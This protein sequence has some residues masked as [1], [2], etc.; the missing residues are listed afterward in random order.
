VAKYCGKGRSNAPIARYLKG[1]QQVRKI[2]RFVMANNV[3]LNPLRH[4][5]D[6]RKATL[7][8]PTH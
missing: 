4:H 2:R 6:R 3:W 1:K 7:K 8:P 5:G